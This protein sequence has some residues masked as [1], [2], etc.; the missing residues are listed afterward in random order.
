[1]SAEDYWELRRRVGLISDTHQRVTV[2]GLDAQRF[3]QDIVSQEM[4]D[5]DIGETRRSLLLGH[6]G[7]LR[8]LLWVHR[9]DVEEFWIYTD[10][11]GGERVAE[12]L[13]RYR[14]RVK[15]EIALDDSSVSSLVGP[16][17]SGQVSA[18]LGRL[19]RYL[20]DNKISGWPVAGEQSATAVRVEEGEPVMGRDIDE[21][22]IPQ[23]AGLVD[24][25][26]SLAKGCYLGQELVA[27]IASRGHV[28][29]H[30]R[31]LTLRAPVEEG[32]SLWLGGKEVGKATSIVYS[33]GLDCYLALSLLR[34]EVTPPGPVLAGGQDGYVRDL[35]FDP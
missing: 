29:R 24:L 6:E 11:G 16:A 32:V 23:E 25:A 10:R 12:D 28:N 26:V 1:M 19:P 31:G 34:R 20:I 30:L 7:K 27:R 5:I 14:I 33:P 15:A 17:A 3:L 35:P 18:P 2:R 22:T 9:S 8:A 4:S 13:T 21:K